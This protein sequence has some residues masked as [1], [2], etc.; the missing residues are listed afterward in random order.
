MKVLDSKRFFRIAEE[1]TRKHRE[2][3]IGAELYKTMQ[4]D[5]KMMRDILERYY[6]L[7]RW[8]DSIG[9]DVDELKEML[10]KEEG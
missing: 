8:Y 5:V 2:T 7:I 9:M 3:K 4:I 1:V 10:E 6:D